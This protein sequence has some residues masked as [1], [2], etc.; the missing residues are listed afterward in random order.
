MS[1]K[2]RQH[3]SRDLLTAAKLVREAKYSVY[4]SSKKC[5]VPWSALKDFLR[6]NEDEEVV[7]QC[8]PKLGKPFALSF[9]LTVIRIRKLAYKLADRNA[10]EKNN[11][12]NKEEEA[13]GEWWWKDFKNRYG[14]CLRVPE[15]IASYSS[16]MANR[17][18]LNDFYDLIWNSDE[19]GLSYVAKSS[20]IVTAI[21]NKYAYKNYMQIVGKIT[22]CLH[23]SMPL[24]TGFN[25]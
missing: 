16:S 19:T 13:T 10:S 17:T 4:K 24:I 6:R 8:L 14:L 3:E 12:F 21:G 22:L 20:K 1:M 23:V 15:N 2:Y 18:I 5:N 25:L 9:G 7:E 11:P